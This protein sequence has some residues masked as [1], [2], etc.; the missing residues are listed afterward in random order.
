MA[1]VADRTLDQMLKTLPPEAKAAFKKAINEVPTHTIH[2][3]SKKC[4]GKLVGEIYE[5]ARSPYVLMVET[6]ESGVARNRKRLDG[7]WGFKCKCGN[8]SILAKEEVGNI[9][10]WTKDEKP[11]R[12]APNTEEMLTI[13]NAIGQ[14]KG[15]PY[16][17]RNGVKNVDGFEIRRAV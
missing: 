2:C 8:D 11:L 14:R 13:A 6:K 4:N 17:E 5:N 3:M 12:D 15:N 16:E 1:H 7:Q 9:P 10:M